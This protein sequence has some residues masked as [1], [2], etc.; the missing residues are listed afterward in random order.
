METKKTLRSI[1][2]IITAVFAA[3]IALTALTF[4]SS[5][6]ISGDYT[7]ALVNGEA[8]ITKYSGTATELVIPSEIDGYKV[9]SV[10]ASTFDGN[11]NLVSVTIPDS[12]KR[13]R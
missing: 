2:Y 12:V 13:N 3:I 9:T 7:Y 5:A 6:E 8:K 10:G 11:R 4:K 1:G